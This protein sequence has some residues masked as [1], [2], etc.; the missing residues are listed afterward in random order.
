MD[1]V[2]SVEIYKMK[3]NVLYCEYSESA[4]G[5]EQD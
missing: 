5:K 3:E 1:Y 2:I 4:M